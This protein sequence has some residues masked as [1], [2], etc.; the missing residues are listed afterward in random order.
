MEE[1][2]KRSLRVAWAGTTDGSESLGGVEEEVSRRPAS[3]GTRPVEAITLFESRLSPVGP[4]DVALQRTSLWKNF[5][6]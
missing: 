4:A 1:G 2:E 5:S 6:S 3:P